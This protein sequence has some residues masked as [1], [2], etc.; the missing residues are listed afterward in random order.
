MLLVLTAV[1]AAPAIARTLPAAVCV[2]GV[3]CI[4][5]MR[6]EK[7]HATSFM[8]IFG[9]FENNSRWGMENVTLAFPVHDRGDGILE[10]AL[11]T[12]QAPILPGGQWNFKAV[13]ANGFYINSATLKCNLIEGGR[14]ATAAFNFLPIFGPD[15]RREQKNRLKQHPEIARQH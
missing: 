8:T 12:L 11:A 14:G 4:T 1:L 6:W 9:T 15:S 2:P 10:S 13:L 5:N 7:D 3:V